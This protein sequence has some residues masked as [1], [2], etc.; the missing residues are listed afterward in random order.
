M[1]GMDE[2]QREINDAEW[3]NSDNWNG[4]WIFPI[5]FSKRDSRVFVPQW[6]NNP[7][8]PTTLNFGNRWTAVV[9]P[10]LTLTVALM[11]GVIGYMLGRQQ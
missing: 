2:S 6:F 4:V 5:S 10:S 3:R 8:M 1:E 7:F 9:L 11:W